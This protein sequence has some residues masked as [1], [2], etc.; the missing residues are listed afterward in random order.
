ML[1]AQ[2][3]FYNTI[4][5]IEYAENYE[6]NTEIFDKALSILK[7]RLAAEDFSEFSDDER[8]ILEEALPLALEGED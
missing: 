7:K 3:R 8:E 5:T 1:S 4:C 6:E 2:V